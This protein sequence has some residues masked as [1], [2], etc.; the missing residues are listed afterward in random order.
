VAKYE[1]ID[2]DTIEIVDNTG[3][4]PVVIAQTTFFELKQDSVSHVMSQLVKQVQ[5]YYKMQY[6]S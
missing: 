3:P 1:Q 6:K 2:A 4:K 5:Q